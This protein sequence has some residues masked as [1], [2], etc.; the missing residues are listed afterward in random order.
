MKFDTD[1]SPKLT[2][3][4]AQSDHALESFGMSKPV[5]DDVYQHLKAA[6]L[7]LALQQNRS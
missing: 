4:I 7:T 6:M 2:H 5:R 3:A 1:S